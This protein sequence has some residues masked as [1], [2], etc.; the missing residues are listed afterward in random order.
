MGDSILRSL[1]I[2]LACFVVASCNPSWRWERVNKGVSHFQYTDGP[3]VLLREG[4]SWPDAD[5][6]HVLYLSF[7][8]AEDEWRQDSFDFARTC[9]AKTWCVGSNWVGWSDGTSLLLARAP[10]GLHFSHSGIVPV[11]EHLFAIGCYPPLMR[12]TDPALVCILELHQDAG[13]LRIEEVLEVPLDL[14]FLE[15]EAISKARGRARTDSP[16]LGPRIG[17][18]IVVVHAD[19]SVLSSLRKWR[20]EEPAICHWGIEYCAERTVQASHLKTRGD[21][22][23]MIELLCEQLYE[24]DGVVI[25]KSWCITCALPS[26]IDRGTVREA[27]SVEQGACVE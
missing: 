8:P 14:R 9:V 2:V 12:R 20:P 7:D 22:S 4:E 17:D 23:Y 19:F 5:R 1:T 16:V 27:M 24:A 26:L 25:G 10:I 6:L 18:D 21:S 15:P 11:S 3:L 13:L